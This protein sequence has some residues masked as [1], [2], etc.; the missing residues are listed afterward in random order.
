MATGLRTSHRRA[1]HPRI[2]AGCSGRQQP[3]AEPFQ[4]NRTQNNPTPLGVILRELLKR[5][6]SSVLGSIK[7]KV[8]FEGWRGTAVFLVLVLVL[9]ATVPVFEARTTTETVPSMCKCG[10]DNPTGACC[11]T[12]RPTSPLSMGCAGSSKPDASSPQVNPLIG[13]PEPI[14]VPVPEL[15]PCDPAPARLLW[16]DVGIRPETPPPRA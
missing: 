10:C 6:L 16:A 1:R 13:P 14:S 8:G 5:R 15:S 3:L 2:P 4:K 11:C 9:P 7:V 12:A